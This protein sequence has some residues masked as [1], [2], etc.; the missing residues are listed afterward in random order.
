MPRGDLISRLSWAGVLGGPLFLLLAV[1]FWQQAPRLF[2]GAAGVAFVG[3]FIVLVARMP[4][5]HE[6]GD[7]GAVV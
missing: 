7:D 1:L 3:G 2:L 6:D 4:G 5:E